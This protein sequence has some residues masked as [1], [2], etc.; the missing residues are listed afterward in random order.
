[1]GGGFSGLKIYKETKRQG[2]KEK[3]GRDKNIEKQREIDGDRNEKARKR[4]R[5]S[6]TVEVP[7]RTDRRMNE[8]IDN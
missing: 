1:M 6:K 8:Q 7:T 4:T 5:H 2:D 3:E